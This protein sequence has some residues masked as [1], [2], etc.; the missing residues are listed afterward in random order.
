MENINIRLYKDGDEEKIANVVARTLQEIN[1]RDY[2]QEVIAEIIN[3][4]DA[5]VI[6]NRAEDSHMYVVCDNEEIIGVGAIAPYYNSKTE[7]IFLTIFLLPEYE[8]KGIGR[9]IIETLEMDEYFKRADRIEIPASITGLNFYRHMGYGF[10]KFG[11]IINEKGD[12]DFYDLMHRF[13]ISF[14]CLVTN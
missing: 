11:N 12:Y 9:K 3:S 13:I 7:S 5:T 14:I 10:K 2:P 6:K 4:H 8:G 1:I